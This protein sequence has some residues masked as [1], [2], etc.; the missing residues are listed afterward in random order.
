[1][2]LENT[3]RKKIEEAFRPSFLEIENESQKHHRPPG[4]ETH[5][6]VVI[7]SE[8]FEGLSRVDRQRKVSGLFKIEFDEGLHAFSQKT[9]TPTE[10][11]SSKDKLTLTTPNCGHQ[12]QPPKKT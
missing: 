9:F 6:R 4:S 10:W 2:K 11:E 5:F 7:V 1:M 3:I 12:M 8:K